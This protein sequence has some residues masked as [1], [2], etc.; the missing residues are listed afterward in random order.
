MPNKKSLTMKSTD[1]NSSMDFRNP[2]ITLQT[3]ISEIV[4]NIYSIEIDPENIALELSRN[5]IHGEVSTNV[6]FILKDKLQKAPTIIGQEIIENLKSIKYIQDAIVAGSGFI[7]MTLHPK[8]WHGFISEVTKNQG[9]FYPDIG[10]GNQVLVEF[11]SANPTGPLHVGHSRGAVFGDALC[12]VLQKVGYKVTREYLVNDAGNQITNLLASALFRYRQLFNINEELQD[13]MYPGEYLIDVAKKLKDKLQDSL[14]TTTP[15]NISVEVRDFILDEILSIIKIDLE[16]LGVKHDVFISE[17]KDIQ[18]KNCI[19]NAID[20]LSA[21]NLVY[22]GV[23]EAPK[24]IKDDEWEPKEQ[25]LF[26][27]TDFGDDQDRSIIKSDGTYTYFAGDLGLAWH[28]VKRGFKDVVIVLGAD[29]I[30]Y[31]KRIKALYKSLD[32]EMKIEAPI[33]QMVNLIKDGG[34][35]KMSKRAGNFITAGDVV[36]EVGKDILRF[37]MLA[38]KNDTKFD[39][40]FDKVKQQSK[41]NPVF[42]VQYAHARC[43][44]VL[45]I[46]KEDLGLEPDINHL[47]LVVTPEELEIVR[48]IA[49]YVKVLEQ[50]AL[51]KDPHRVMNYIIELANSFHTFWAKGNEFKGYRVINSEDPNLTSARLVLVQLVKL[52][53][54]SGLELLG[55][56]PVERM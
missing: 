17:K 13:E 4:H 30:G 6:A 2:W 32:P 46:A 35:F 10:K 31:V 7:N 25:L 50:A 5:P 16:K 11:V 22:R 21:N 28:R 45:R 27:S 52:C 33:T 55:V 39:F 36:D 1:H 54:S 23:L 53:I 18:E 29:H 56:T 51:N 20:A 47:Y 40:D 24:G 3:S 48:K 38:R 19:Q 14:I 15:D 12:S 9:F 49:W 44:S 43:C 26:K 34:P 42:Y 37:V 8:A 41:D